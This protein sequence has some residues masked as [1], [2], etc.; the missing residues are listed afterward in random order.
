MKRID[1]I[2]A[3]LVEQSQGKTL[4]E[5]IRIEGFTAS[6][7]A[8]DLGILRN[9]VSA[10]LNKLLRQKRIIKIKG[11][12][13]HYLVKQI[14]EDLLGTKLP[15]DQYE[16]ENILEVTGGQSPDPGNG[17]SANH[18]TA[19]ETNPFDDLIGSKTSLK[20]QVEQAKAAV[21]YPPHGL[22]T[23][24]VGQTGVGKTLFAN[25][26]FNY[27]KLAAPF[28]DE[29]A[30][31]IV[32]NCADYANNPQLLISHIFGHIKGAFT[33]AD[34]EKDGLV[35]KADGGMLFLDEIHR[36]PPEGQE[37]LFYFMDTGTYAKLGETERNRNANVLIVGAT[38]EDPES[39]LLKTFVRRIPILIR[40]PSFEERPAIDKIEILKFLLAIEANRVQKPIKIDAESMKALIGNTSYGN[41]GQLKS[42]IQLVC[43]NGFLHCLH[44]DVITIHFK[45]L[46]SELKNGFFYFSR[47][48]QEIQELSDLIDSYLTVYPEGE[49]KALFEEDPYEPDFNLYN[50]IEDKVSFMM[51][52]DVS[53]EDINRF[54][55]LD[56]DIHL[57]K[58]Y[59]KFSSYALN[60]EKILKIVSEDI[61]NFSEEVQDIVEK[62]LKCKVNERFLLA[63][64][65]HLT[66]FLKRVKN[67]QVA[68]YTNIENVINDRPQEYQLSLDICKMIGE[69]YR[70]HVPVK[71]A[72]YLTILL[73]S[74]IDEQKAEQVAILVAAHGFSTASSMVSVVKSLLGESNVDCID[75]PLDMDPKYVLE[76]MKRRV[77]EI[78]MGKG[79]LLLVDM[80]S[81]TGF[82]DVITQETGIKTRT[83]DMVTTALVI[84]AIRKAT[85]MEMDLDDIYESLKEFRGYGSYQMESKPRETGKPVKPQ[86]ILSVCS[87]GEGTA[88]KLKQLITRLLKN[89][90]KTN[91]AV[92]P[93]PINEV[94]EKKEML[95][96]KYDILLA[97]GIADPKVQA[98][99]VPLESLFMGDGETQVTHLIQNHQLLKQPPR[100]P[101]MVREM[102]E[103]SL[104]EFLTFLNPKKVITAITAFVT[105]LEKIAERPFNNASK[106][107]M[108][109]HIG[110]ALERMVTH[111]GLIYKNDITPEKTAKIKKY[112][113]AAQIFEDQLK[114]KLSDDELYYI[115]DMI[116]HLSAEQTA[117]VR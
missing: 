61:L 17:P 75:M 63:F 113:K 62:R 65:L 23:L 30:Q 11:R 67:Q 70:V 15:E 6:D 94:E 1:R 116:D 60:R 52:Q 38:T 21:L 58:F 117:A 54:L 109:I 36:L 68:N 104:N 102:T 89:I 20:V 41:V 85:I 111:S 93:L 43:A 81:L 26:M 50:I 13:V 7:I 82:G 22:H 92:I 101:A 99:F 16:Y 19:W 112:K 59:N 8:K 78:D 10:E 73:T 76:E 27:A 4:D 53:D 5:W 31:F 97:V 90:G 2:Y 74:L 77:K 35:S 105:V 48:R 95:M 9:N 29:D 14:M 18:D 100:S 40:I 114:L 80:G 42:N 107:N 37:M 44:D 108:N 39:S 33:G 51:E 64:S 79:V 56:I 69:K 115:A 49:N 72:M 25:L 88:E 24:I 12:P 103:E 83:I 34:S 87:T 106:I 46:P 55:K 71:E 3:Y 47:K 96:Q 45:D 66:S 32:F 57:N 86:A 28:M 84:E 98:P 110:C 91:I